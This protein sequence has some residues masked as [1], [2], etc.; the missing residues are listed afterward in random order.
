LAGLALTNNHSHAQTTAGAAG[1][2]TSFDVVSVRQSKPGAPPD[3]KL[4]NNRFTANLTLFG[5]IEFA[6]NLMPSRDQMDSMLAHAPKWVSTDNF[7]I[8]AVAEGNPTPDQMRLMVR[9]LLADRFRLQVHPVT[10]EAAV[11]ALILDKPG[12]TGPKLRPRSEGR[13]CD[14]HSASQAV[15]AFPPECGRLMAIG[16]PHGAVLVAA[17]D[18]T[19][20]QIASF[21]SSLGILTRPAV[22]QTGLSGQFDFTIEFT[23]ERKGPP[24]QD[25][26]PDDVQ[27]TTLQ[28]AL[29]EQ[30]GLK[31]KATR[32][33]L[34][35][36]IVDR[37][38][39][40]SEN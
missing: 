21:I 23:P 26:Q 13:P 11:I 10:E 2:A 31:L 32:A 40:P 33:P 15:G 28:E 30:L 4:E 18:V 19:L 9:S 17:R 35:T 7:E 5:Y 14:I 20:Q 37:A 1:G 6:W 8:R 39:R 22:D 29:R 16:A 25:V 27:S 12:I 38:E 24:P 3:E 36:L 34:Q